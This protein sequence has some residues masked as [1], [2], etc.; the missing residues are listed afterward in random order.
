MVI[1]RWLILV[2][3]LM[4]M[5]AP[6]LSQDEEDLG[7]P[8]GSDAPAGVVLENLDGGPVSLADYVGKKPVLLEFWAT[9]CGVCKALEPRMQAAHEKYGDAVEFLIVAVGVNQNPRTVRRHLAGHALPGTFLWD[10][11]GAAV[12]AYGAPQTSY[13]VTVNRSGKIAYTGIGSDQDLDRA[14]ARA[15]AN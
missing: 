13:V 2:F 15:M 3:G 10:G 1:S 8:V 5:P 6:L 11:K 12:R 7:I 9:W 4:A 14:V